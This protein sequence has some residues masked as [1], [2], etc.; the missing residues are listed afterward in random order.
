MKRYVNEGVLFRRSR[1]PDTAR[2]ETA[3]ERCPSR[4]TISTWS[5]PFVRFRNWR[6]RK[7][8]RAVPIGTTSVGFLNE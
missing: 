8:V 5:R 3:P 4:K 1:Q 7:M 6:V 2:V